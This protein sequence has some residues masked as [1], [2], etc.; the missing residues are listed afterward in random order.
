MS[1]QSIVAVK[2]AVVANGLASVKLATTPE[3]AWL[4]A[5]FVQVAASG[6]SATFAVERAVAVLLGVS[7]SVIV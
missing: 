6:A 3:Y 2:S 1:P 7:M 5:W 4:E